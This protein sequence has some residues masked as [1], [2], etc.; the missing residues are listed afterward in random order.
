MANP[1]ITVEIIQARINTANELFGASEHAQKRGRI[2]ASRILHGL[3]NGILAKTP[4][5]LKEYR[6]L[7]YP[8][9][10]ESDRNTPV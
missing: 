7:H 1:E 10:T 5:E 2:A 8:E 3:G 4:A 9:E 6:R